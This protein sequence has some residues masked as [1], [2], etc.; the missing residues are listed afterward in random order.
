MI[1]FLG[2]LNKIYV[3]LQYTRREYQPA[4][5]TDVE[6][7]LNLEIRSRLFPGR[8]DYYKAVAIESGLQIQEHQKS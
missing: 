2:V 4:N 6:I 8:H 5:E 3:K 7:E 1:L